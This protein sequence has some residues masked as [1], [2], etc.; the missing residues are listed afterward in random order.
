MHI[1]LPSL[2]C[3]NFRFL[4]FRRLAAVLTIKELAQNAPAAFYSKTNQFSFGKEGEANDF[5][6]QLSVLGQEGGTNAFISQ[7]FP[8]LTDPQPIVRV[9]A[10]DALAECLE[11]IVDPSRKHHST[12]R[13]LCQVY[14]HIMKV[15]QDD[16]KVKRS[17]AELAEIEAAQHAA[18]LVV[19]DLLE[20]PLDFMLPR[21]DEVCKATL[22][23]MDHPKALIRV[24]VIRLLVSL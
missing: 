22:S 3:S 12:T 18:L 14:S 21:F 10:A 11:V 6:A 4:G 1:F 16:G 19:G 17:H 8:V 9:C 2:C 15:F 13:T 23:L 20:I 7:I 24:E 5:I